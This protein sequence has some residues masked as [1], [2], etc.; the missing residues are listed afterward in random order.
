MRGD[1]YWLTAKW[2]GVCR[3]C[4]TRIKRGDKAYYYPSD[5]SLF[6]GADSCGEKASREFAALRQ[7][8]EFYHG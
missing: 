4:G 1:P 3:R 7:D 6:C 2:P 5:K 8:E